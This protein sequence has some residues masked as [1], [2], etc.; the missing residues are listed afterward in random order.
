M[1]PSHGLPRALGASAVALCAIASAASSEAPPAAFKQDPRTAQ[2]YAAAKRA[3]LGTAV[4]AERYLAAAAHIADMPSYSTGAPSL[5]STATVIG[6]WANLGPSNV[7]GRT[8]A[9]IVHPTLPDTW[10]AAGV[11][12]GVFKTSNAA[13]TPW[14]ALGDIMANMAVSAL[15]MKPGTPTTLLAGTGEGF[16]NE[17]LVR[18]AGIFQTLNGG[19]T[20]TQLASTNNANFY[21]VNDLVWSTNPPYTN[22]YAATDTG[23][24]RSL[25]SGATW[26]Q[27]LAP[28]LLG[29]CLDL[30]L[31]P[32]AGDFILASCGTFTTAKIYR[33]QGT[34][35]TSI[36]GWT[37]V[38]SEAGMGRTSLSETKSTGTV[39]ALSADLTTQALHAVFRSD[40]G[41][42]NWI[43]K[44]DAASA[45]P[46]SL[47]LQNALAKLCY[48]VDDAVGWY[49][50]TIAID[51]SDPSGNTVWSGS[52]DV[53]RST[54]GG[55][56]W[57]PMSSWWEELLPHHVPPGQHALVF[58]AGSL[59]VAGDGGIFQM[60]T[61]PSGPGSPPTCPGGTLSTAE[62][63]PRNYG[64][65]V[66][67]FNSAAVAPSDTTYIG[68]IQRG[69]LKGTDAAGD[70]GWT[71]IWADYG[72]A[73][74]IDPTDPDVI[75][76]VGPGG[77]LRKSF[78]GGIT[79]PDGP[80]PGGY[81][82][83]GLSGNFA[84]QPAFAIDPTNPSR[85]WIA[86][87]D[88]IFRS[89]NGGGLWVPASASLGIGA[90]SI[91]V[92]PANPEVVAIGSVNGQVWRTTAASSTG[93]STIWLVG[94]APRLGYVSS[95]AF[96]P[97]DPNLLYATYGT[98]GGV[99][100]WK[101]SNGGGSWADADG[102][103][104]TGIPDLPV[105]SV[106]VD[107]T[108]AARIYAGTDA[109]VFVSL[110]RGTSWA[111]ENTG[112]PNVIT[113]RLVTSGA[114]LYAFTHGRGA[115]R[116]PLTTGTPTTTV[117]FSAPRTT[118]TEEGVVVDVDVVL[119]TANHLPLAG[120]VTVA[121][122]SASGGAAAG[123]DFTPVS[124]TLTF[125]TSA[126]HGARLTFAVPI[127]EDGVGEA[128]E[129]FA[130]NLS[131]PTGGA[132]L[133]LPTHT[134]AIEDDADPPG[135][136]VSNV[137][138]SEGS[139]SV[140]FVVNLTTALAVP[141]TVNYATEDG[142]AVAGTTGDY[143]AVSGAL[144]FPAGITAKTV[145]VPIKA[146]TLAEPPET[147]SLRLSGA[148][149]SAIVDDL[150]VATINDNDLA[151]SLQF[152]AA[153]YT[154]AESG[155]KATITVTRTGGSAS[156]VT[157][158]YA[159][160]NGTAV[161]PGDYT[162]AS[163]TL[164]FG[165][166]IA[167]Q[168]FQVTIANDTLDESDET[169]QLTLLTPGG[170]GATLGAQTTA[171]LSITDNDAGGEMAFSSAT[172][173]ANEGTA[174]L[175]TVKRTGGTAS[176]VSVQYATVPDSATSPADYAATT[177][178]LTFAS[179]ELQKTF[180][181]PLVAENPILVEG[182]ETFTV[183]LSSPQGGAT[184]SPTLGTATV[185]IADASPRVA[186]QAVATTVS[187][188]VTS[189]ALN[190]VR[191]G[192]VGTAV[193]VQYASSDGSATA[194]PVG[195]NPADYTAASSSLVI[196]AGATSKP[197]TVVLK[198]DTVAEGPESFTVTLGT[199]TGGVL[200]ANATVTVN[201]TDNDF[202]GVIAFAAASTDAIEPLSGVLPGKA[203]VTVKRTGGLASGV[204]VHWA[205]DNGTA[206]APD[207]YTAASGTVT[208]D[209]GTTSKTFTVDVLPD[210]F[211]EGYESINLSLDTPT[212]GSSLGALNTAA[213]NVI[214]SEPVVQ[215]TPAAVT[216]GEGGLKATFTV[217]RT[218]TLVGALTVGIADLG[219]GT[220]TPG[221]GGDYNNVPLSLVLPTNAA[222]KT[223][224]VD[225]L[226]DPAL[227][228]METVNLRL[229]SCAPGCTV[230]PLANAVLSIT[231]DE[232]LVSFSAATYA[233]TEGTAKVTL[234]LKRTGSTAAALTVG[235]LET[236]GT[237][238]GGGVDYNNVPATVLIPAKAATKT[239]T[240][241]IVNDLL[242]ETTETIGL[243]INSV[244]GGGF[245]G[246][247]PTT[248][249]NLADNEPTIAFSLAS[250]TISEPP[251]TGSAPGKLTVAV[252]RT[253]TLTLVS[254]VAYQI[255]DV[256]ATAGSDYNP[257]PPAALSGTLTFASGVAS[258][259]L[260]IDIVAD[261]VDE[262]NE[263][264]LLS[265]SNPTAAKL[266]ANVNA[267]AT[268]T[269][270]DL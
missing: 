153:N 177:G 83:D 201:I 175:I 51:P 6:T 259:N 142:T 226:Q 121:Y 37:M 57:S 39:Y 106:V 36:A 150:G 170:F 247:L 260:V 21:Y 70:L 258:M 45:T 197:I 59:L 171:T 184:I 141:V 134:V 180:S 104:V 116:V 28:S 257:F 40:D 105:H 151:G 190:V 199:V 232:P 72:G 10:Y 238:T 90:T 44:A 158:Q 233:V 74:V 152:S 32:G 73:A 114:N 256:T 164:T 31:A 198:T 264:F 118:V 148:S 78:D 270:N 102:A 79:F 99:H 267:T 60:T 196:P 162:P 8:R 187:E 43:R 55:L 19:T 202:G 155:L 129:T 183:V 128:T 1:F 85:L 130:L 119:S 137:E 213:I 144:L 203:T 132:L 227:E 209:A 234:T 200:G 192:P 41:G 82:I 92:S 101:S 251:N 49:A 95:L 14:T 113:E 25:N 210:A 245:I 243:Q 241:D 214:D 147:F 100:L 98:F 94:L 188:S 108:N 93:E 186:F 46:S 91:A 221:A 48:G 215:F 29:G 115:W 242:G 107:P 146:D 87:E 64:Y 139:P 249:V 117:G 136:S 69:T 166:N 120:P 174:V 138:V 35:A 81:W 157:V 252:K 178:T 253:G 224:T 223:F 266:G 179:G 89:D 165:A 23:V 63:S 68:G 168:T 18:G 109:G 208:F 71:R 172:Y 212:G 122:A 248:V 4:P 140:T 211:V 27:I 205:T 225:I 124:G 97:L 127:L 38:L 16:F 7:G 189:V 125:L 163:G 220:A 191:T 250:Y 195:S 13:L 53:Y 269:D 230:G 173:T 254:T 30:S 24:F 86:G 236:G 181:V 204:T 76:V 194:A 261:L 9:L 240:I 154:V 123:S 237:A 255:T 176:G 88:R 84:N 75:Y 22:V 17:D 133:A 20:W 112:F 56:T 159:T 193:T 262:A 62:F 11:A 161:A 235:I 5:D 58:G 160:G 169:V 131:A 135:L 217:K 149:G 111:K 263:T 218:G 52:I 246:P 3:P 47:I 228:S 207:D 65:A 265:L 33:T 110:N 66:T 206:V 239:F 156:G 229:T 219:T 34:T 268:I 61:A 126:P 2:R 96:D 50:N 143:T 54:D 42:V 26:T 185:K 216:V 222:T 182:E 15:V 80:G 231:D 12:G 167:S 145:I 244:T 103:G 67:Q 77:A